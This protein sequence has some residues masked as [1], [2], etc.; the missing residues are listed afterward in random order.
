MCA[1]GLNRPFY[2]QPSPLY[3][4]SYGH[5][6]LY[7]F[8]FTNTSLL[9]IFYLQHRPTEMRD[10]HKNKLIRKEDYK[11]IIDTFYKQHLFATPG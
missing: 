3:L 2:R 10:K 4:F 6:P 8:F 5:A 9:T 1:E 7:I 11:T